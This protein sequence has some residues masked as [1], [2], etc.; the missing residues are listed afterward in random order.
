MTTETGDAPDTTPWWVGRTSGSYDPSHPKNVDGRRHDVSSDEIDWE[1]IILATQ[2]DFESGRFSYNSRQYL[3]RGVA[4]V[5]LAVWLNSIVEDMEREPPWLHVMPHVESDIREC[6]IFA[7][8]RG[9][10][11]PRDRMSDIRR[12]LERVLGRPEAD[13]VILWRPES[14]I[15][16]R[17]SNAGPF[18]IIYAYLYPCISFPHGAASIRAIR[19][20]RLKNSLAMVGV[21]SPECAS[22]T[23]QEASLCARSDA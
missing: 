4:E 22:S 8:R 18:F 5:G 2:E 1:E 16:L 9:W 19:Y 15:F 13:P 7:A 10:G 17:R 14:G 21:P 12:G 6:L 23:S 3:S 11:A 20:S